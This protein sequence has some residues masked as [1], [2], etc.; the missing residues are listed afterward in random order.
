M[1]ASDL[2]CPLYTKHTLGKK[3]THKKVWMI[4]FTC[5]LSRAVHLEIMQN[6]SAEQFITALG[7]FISR[8]GKPNLLISDNAKTFKKSNK[9]LQELFQ[10]NF[11]Q[12]YSK[13]TS[14]RLR[15][16]LR[17]FLEMHL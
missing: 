8:R 5:A 9:M 12:S 10:G 13:A 14:S 1:Y 15:G 2:A 4:I 7:R 6:M 17:R 16:T 11:K 3:E